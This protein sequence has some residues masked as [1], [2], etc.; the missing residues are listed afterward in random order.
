MLFQGSA[1][2]FRTPAHFLPKAVNN[3]LTIIYTAMVVVAGILVS[4]KISRQVKEFFFLI[5]FLS[6]G[7]YGFF[8]SQTSCIVLEMAVIP[9]FM[10]IGVWG[11]GKKEY[12]AMKL[13]LMLMGGSALFMGI[14][15]LYVH[16]LVQV[17]E[18]IHS[19][20]KTV[21]YSYPIE[22]QRVLLSFSIYWIRRFYGAL[23]PFIHGFPTADSSAPTA[24]SMFLPVFQ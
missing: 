11:S 17:K 9:K 3:T 19:I 18:F 20:W 21:K 14:A 12:S 8:I 7:A 24:A 2:W 1:E 23:F 5:I 13:A 16:S 15:G 6:L 22:K 10:L 4:W